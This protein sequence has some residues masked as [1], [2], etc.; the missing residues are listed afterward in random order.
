MRS[1][2]LL[3]ALAACGGKKPARHDAAPPP[4]ADAAAAHA[5][6]S[7]LADAA[8]PHPERVEHDA[9]KLV[10]QRALAHREVA[11]E[12]VLDARGV[13]FARFT[14]FGLPAPHW[15]LGQEVDGTRAAIADRLASLEVPLAPEQAGAT[16]VTARVHADGKQAV[17]LKI[18]GRAGGKLARVALE[19][20]W[21]TVA[22]AVE[23]GR[24]VPGENELAF[25]TRGGK[26]RAAFAWLRLGSSHP[27]ADD[28]PLAAA[29]FD[30]A[31]DAL[32]LAEGAQLAWY[33]AIPDGAN[34]V[35]AVAGA[36]RVEVAARAGD[37][38]LAGGLL[39]GGKDRVDLSPVAGKVVRLALR[40][41]DCARARLVHPRITLYGPAPAPLPASEPPH[42]VVVWRMQGL[43]ADHLPVIAPGARAAAPSFEE[44]AKASTVFR[45]FYAPGGDEHPLG[46][47]GAP[48]RAAGFTEIII[49]NRK[50]APLPAKTVVDTALR[51]LESHRDG[52]I[53]LYITTTDCD[54]PAPAAADVDAA[55]ARYDAAIT[56]QDAELG[57]F[58]HQ[59]QAWGIW[60]Q[61]LLIVTA[62]HGEE[63]AEDGRWGHGAS[64][65]EAVLH[66]PLLVHDPARFPGGTVVEEGATA[67]SLVPTVLAALGR[68][69][70][71]DAT[72]APLE[73]LA[74]GIGRGWPRAAYAEDGDQAFAVRLGRWKGRVDRSA[75]LWLG[76]LVTD[77][78][79]T[80]DLAPALPVERRMLADQLG[81]YLALRARWRE[82]SWGVTSNLTADGAVA[83]DQASTP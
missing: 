18:N 55:R 14:R 60:D 73:P 44:L 22:L 16:Q 68:P 34:L 4:P 59:L 74:Q 17:A 82:A 28:D 3:L 41:R 78:D 81:L 51:E 63:L 57:R 29:T 65:R 36:C 2:V 26:T 40:G 9:W 54:L 61:T 80:R 50:S 31:G 24:L 8:A 43:R 42:F 6:A 38:S 66:V 25:E 49:M 58:V 35:G 32:E 53:C 1:G 83:L 5:Q 56:A 21:Q 79:E 45:T 39:G 77:P 67:E 20:G 47:L 48:V 23:P 75:V 11:G 33:V 37:G 62:E 72:G 15:R 70:P 71:A 12:V 46:A 69:A 64:L 30:P 10:D 27:R 76:D 13:G 52:K 19:P 7:P